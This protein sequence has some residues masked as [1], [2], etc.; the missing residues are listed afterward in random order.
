MCSLVDRLE[1]LMISTPN[2]NDLV[3]P[4]VCEED[5]Y[6]NLSFSYVQQKKNY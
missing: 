1:V 4:K 5:N 2:R 3:F 6:T